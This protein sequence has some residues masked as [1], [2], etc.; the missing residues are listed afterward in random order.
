M[1]DE[2]IPAGFKVVKKRLTILGC[3]NSASTFKEK[4]A[5]ID[6]KTYKLSESDTQFTGALLCK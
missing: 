5:V 1:V 2:T 3:A 6:K 4:L